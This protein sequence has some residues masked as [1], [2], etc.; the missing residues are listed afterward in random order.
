MTDFLR[1]QQDHVVGNH[2]KSAF[3]NLKF[4]TGKLRARFATPQLVLNL[5]ERP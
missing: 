2:T 4:S 5:V 1:L 3:R